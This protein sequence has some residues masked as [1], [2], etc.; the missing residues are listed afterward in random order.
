MKDDRL[1]IVHMK[2]RIEMIQNFTQDGREEFLQS[3]MIQEAVI[4]CFE[5]IG[6]AARQLAEELRLKYPEI[7]WSKI[8]GMRNILIHNY[9]NVDFHQ[10]WEIIEHNL[11]P[12]YTQLEGILADLSEE[13][14]E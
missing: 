1:Y 11:P 10:V 12:L 3:E 5:V 2:E 13:T 8:I 9:Q 4:R 14:D 6:E 7:T